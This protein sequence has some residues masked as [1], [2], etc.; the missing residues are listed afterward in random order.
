MKLVPRLI[1]ALLINGLIAILILAGGI[2]LF[3]KYLDDYTK[4]G[5]TIEVPDIYGFHTSELKSF[6]DDKDFRYVIIDSVY[7]DKAPKGIV[8][9]Q[10]PEKGRL[11]KPGRMIYLTINS[12]S[13][14][15]VIFPAIEDLTYRAADPVLRSRGFQIDTPIVYRPSDA[16]VVL[17]AMFNGDRVFEGDTL[18]RGSAIQ[19]VVGV[20]SDS[21]I[22][23]PNLYG[24]SYDEIMNA[25][26]EGGFNLSSV[27]YAPGVKNAEDSA[28]SFLYRQ[29]PEFE[30]GMMVRPGQGFDIFLGTD[31]NKI[32]QNKLSLTIDSTSFVKE[33][34]TL[35]KPI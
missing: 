24:K 19:L 31:S 4:H 2:F 1:K 21:E 26:F 9:E 11:V 23:V 8:L 33:V 16:E 25:L 30:P 28:K 7:N 12:N 18:E 34:D 35:Q 17:G 14:P 32:P 3:S 15:K 10:D 5:E 13:T 29:I 27:R 6:F 22:P 20:L